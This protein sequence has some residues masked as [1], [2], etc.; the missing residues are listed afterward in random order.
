MTSTR[1]IRAIKTAY[2]S[3]VV[4]LSDSERTSILSV[5]KE[6]TSSEIELVESIKAD[7]LGGFVLNL[8]NYQLD[9]S[10]T[11]ESEQLRKDFDKT[12]M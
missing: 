8:D 5:L 1:N 7:I 6:L 11:A 12:F 9:Q 2:V 3:T 10:V 4:P